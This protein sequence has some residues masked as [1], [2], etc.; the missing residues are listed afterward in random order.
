[1]SGADRDRIGIEFIHCF[2]KFLSTCVHGRL[3]HQLRDNTRIVC[4]RTG[5]DFD[6]TSQVLCITLAAQQMFPYQ[7]SLLQIPPPTLSVMLKQTIMQSSQSGREDH[8]D[9]NCSARCLT[10]VAAPKACPATHVSSTFH[11]RA[12]IL[13]DLDLLY[14]RQ[15]LALPFSQVIS[16]H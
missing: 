3:L 15:F 9:E 6:R 8:L 14:P 10:V 7:L 1:M 5:L 13:I 2:G 12:N 11:A 4:A 16:I